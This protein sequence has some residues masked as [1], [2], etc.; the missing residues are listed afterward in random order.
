MTRR[1]SGS[2]VATGWRIG[3]PFWRG[4]LEGASR[5]VSDALL[6]EFALAGTADDVIARLGAYA[7]A[8]VQLP[9]L[10]P[11]ATAEPEVRRVIDA[12]REFARSGAA[13]V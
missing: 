3:E 2:A 1:T 10:Q 12:G 11:V 7:E 4:D 8:G 9:I 13:A 6:D 5:E